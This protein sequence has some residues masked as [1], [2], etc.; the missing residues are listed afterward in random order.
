MVLSEASTTPSRI[1]ILIIDD[2]PILLDSVKELLLFEGYDVHAVCA[3][4][5]GLALA[6]ELLP[7]CILLDLK[8][9]DTDGYGVLRQLK[10]H[11]VTRHIPVIVLSAYS[12]EQ[13]HTEALA[14][15]AFAFITKPFNTRALLAQIKKSVLERT[16]HEHDTGH[17]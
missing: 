2:D 15:G 9:R 17:G 10:K 8:L 7:R 13:Y 5:D 6:G 4:D 12:Q 11:Q 1:P 16:S 14:L 3:G